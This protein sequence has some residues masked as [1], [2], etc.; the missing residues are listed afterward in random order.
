MIEL[1]EHHTRPRVP[2]RAPVERATLAHQVHD[3]DP[4]DAG[5]RVEL[6]DWDGEAADV[7]LPVELARG[8]LGRGSDGHDRRC[9]GER[10]AD[11]GR[12]G[13][14]GEAHVSSP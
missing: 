10:G 6:E 2:S 12:V 5:R 8:L 3:P 7:Q 11:F 13:E 4:G 1:Y 9:C 14:G